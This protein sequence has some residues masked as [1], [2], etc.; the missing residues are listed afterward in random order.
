MN[1][2]VLNKLN[3]LSVLVVED[4]E[5]AR[6][7]IKHEIKPYCLNFFEAND[8]FTGL[9]VFKNHPIDVIVTDIH[10]PGI[11][12]LDMIDEI[13]KLKPE[14]LF[15]VMTSYDTD[16][17][18]MHSIK[19]GVCSFLRKPLSIND[20]RTALLMTLSRIKYTTKILNEN[21]S[22]DYQKEII[23]FNNEPFF[24]PHKT[25][26]VFWLLCY[27]IGNLVSYEMFENYAYDG[28]YVSK[29]AL[30]NA[31]LRIKKQL[32]SI[33]IENI[34]SDGYILKIKS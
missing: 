12:G 7:T 5:I 14:Q 28:E 32:Y 8:G 33:E 6:K 27:N 13:L 34:S 11:N 23:Y 30:H 9:E 17:N 1:I 24:L 18:I 25:S 19:E 16:Q 3:K 22:I 4:D 31:I 26:R 29:S 15:I 21:I 20:L 10:M 2:Q